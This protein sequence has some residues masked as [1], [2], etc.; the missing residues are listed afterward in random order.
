MA[1]RLE[2]SPAHTHKVCSFPS[3]E[4]SAWA[5]R[6]ASSRPKTKQPSIAGCSRAPCLPM[7]NSPSRVN[8]VTAA[9]KAE[10]WFKNT[11]RCRFPR[12]YIVHTS[13]GSRKELQRH[14]ET[15]RR[16]KAMRDTAASVQQKQVK[17]SLGCSSSLLSRECG[18]HWSSLASLA[19]QLPI[20]CQEE[21]AGRKFSVPVS[22]RRENDS[23]V[24][25]DTGQ[26]PLGLHRHLASAL[27]SPP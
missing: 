26:A 12:P 14:T 5:P 27:R 3:P 16:K 19:S 18:G 17:N 24:C 9:C 25:F 8:C 22:R 1:A 23:P 20:F 4:M 7:R 6:V 13:H 15:Q 11:A 21:R 10:A 2:P